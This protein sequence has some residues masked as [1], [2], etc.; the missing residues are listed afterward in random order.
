VSETAFELGA[1]MGIALL[2]ST[3]NAIYRRSIDLP[4]GLDPTV[5]S[6]AS[7]TIARAVEIGEGLDPATGAAVIDAAQQAFTSGMNGA[8]LLGASLL[9]LIA[10]TAFRVLRVRPTAKV[11]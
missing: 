8:G 4:D 9:L 6:E 2:G 7:D 10:G 3:V 5:A 1:A 11:G